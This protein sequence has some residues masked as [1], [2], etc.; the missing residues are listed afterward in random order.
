MNDDGRVE[1]GAWQWWFDPFGFWLGLIGVC[2]IRFLVLVSDG[3][4]LG[5]KAIAAVLWWLRWV[6]CMTF[7]GI[8]GS[9]YWV[10]FSSGW[11]WCDGCQIPP[12]TV[13]LE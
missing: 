12:P 11:L 3:W 8:C 13:N 7:L 6:N 10:L 1:N 4:V 9:G 5:I 2:C